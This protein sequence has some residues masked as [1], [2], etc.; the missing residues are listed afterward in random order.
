MMQGW[1]TRSEVR[2]VYG[3]SALGE[4]LG[5]LPGKTSGR[6]PDLLAGRSFQA[7]TR[8]NAACVRHP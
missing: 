4:W 7:H 8:Q 1:R 2:N 5:D 6:V 3:N